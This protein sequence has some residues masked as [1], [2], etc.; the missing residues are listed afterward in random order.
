MGTLFRFIAPIAALNNVKVDWS[1]RH[2][3]Q[4]SNIRI[5]HGV[6][7]TRVRHVLLEMLKTEGD[8]SGDYI[9]GNSISQSYMDEMLRSA[10]LSFLY[11]NQCKYQA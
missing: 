11:Q 7:C 10:V 5:K 6:S 1:S 3:S 2:F 9:W 8:I 4:N